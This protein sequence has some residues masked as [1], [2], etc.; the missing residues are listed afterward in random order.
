MKE[1]YEE[2]EVFHNFF[3]KLP[4]ESHLHPQKIGTSFTINF[5]QFLQNVDSFAFC[6]HLKTLQV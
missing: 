2:T 3:G 4:A 5:E 6:N 1:L